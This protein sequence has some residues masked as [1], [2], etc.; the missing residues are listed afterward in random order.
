MSYKKIYHFLGLSTAVLLGGILQPV[1]GAEASSAKSVNVNNEAFELKQEAQRL[2]TQDKIDEALLKYEQAL[3]GDP[4]V[5]S[6]SEKVQ[7]A[8]YY[9][10]VDKL[11]EGIALLRTADKEHPNNSEVK[12][13]LARLLSWKNNP[14]EAMKL[15]DDVLQKDPT[16]V[17]ALHVK[18]D[19]LAWNVNASESLSYY[20]KALERGDNFDVRL[21]YAYAQLS[22]GELDEAISERSKLVP[23]FSY[24]T[25]NLAKLD[26]AIQNVKNGQLPR[27]Q[28]SSSLDLPYLSYYHDS[29]GNIVKT[30]RTTYNFNVKNF[31]GDVSYR[32]GDASDGRLSNRFDTINANVG[33]A[34]LTSLR[35]HAGIGY[36]INRSGDT[37]KT[38]TGHLGTN[39]YRGDW[40]AG[41]AVYREA[42][43]DTAVLIDNAIRVNGGE[44]YLSKAMGARNTIYGSYG[45]RSYS[46]NNYANDLKVGI[47]HVLD[48][49][50]PRVTLGYAIRYLDFERQS[51]GGYFDP[52]NFLSHQLFARVEYHDGKSTY[53]VDPY[54]GF[55]SFDR[56]NQ[57]SN[58]FYGGGNL[59]W[60][61]Q[62]MPKL[63]SE[64]NAEGGNYAMQQ[65]SGYNYYMLGARLNLSF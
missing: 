37:D 45:H 61:Y 50:N 64:L 53:Y 36:A 14:K 59:R 21:G 38:M 18:A 6:V 31:T 47:K 23:R 4:N 2:I 33:T 63:Y 13:L 9:S 44:A 15:S 54:V 48:Y 8:R 58:D 3:K 11:D 17:E 10:W 51:L 43:L 56:N 41:A 40:E 7:L 65:A 49:T 60:R 22:A 39:Y 1:Y 46:D 55:Q 30:V 34:L 29:D 12:V 26:V 62:W 35:V 20:Q 52:N 32:Y 57:S 27:A 28:S 16:N 19:L 5:L 42:M 25:V 24:Q